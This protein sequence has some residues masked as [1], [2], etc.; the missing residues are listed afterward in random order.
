MNLRTRLGMLS[1]A[2]AAVSAL[3]VSGAL[4]VADARAVV[5]RADTHLV[6]AAAQA[7][8]L[9]R[10]IKN[11]PDADAQPEV[12]DEP[13]TI[14]DVTL[15]LISTPGAVGDATIAGPLT[16]ADVDVARRQQPS[17]PS[18]RTVD[19]ERYRVYLSPFGSS[20]GLVV[21]VWPRATG[22]AAQ[23]EL[24]LRLFAFVLVTA[25][26]AGLLGRLIAG[27]ALAPVA[28]LTRTAE[29]I[30]STGD[31]ARRIE[32]TEPDEV[33]RLTTTINSMLASLEQSVSAQ[34]QLVADA[35]HELRTP[36][37][38]LRINLDLLAEAPALSDPNAPHL[39]AHARRQ[40]DQLTELVADLVALARYGQSAAPRHPVRLDD[41][42]LAV[43]ARHADRPDTRPIELDV[44]AAVVDGDEEALHRA[45]SNLVD[46]AIAW[47]PPDAV[48]T[49]RVRDGRVDVIDRGPGID[50]GDVPHVFERF[51]RSPAARSKPGSGLG[52]A[53]VHQ[54]A[55]QHGGSV[56]VASSPAGSTLT[57]RIPPVRPAPDGDETP[58]A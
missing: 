9:A 44:Q 46:N 34:R 19:G 28:R 13:L 7:D 56:E 57:M 15:Q 48:V 14:G 35:S 36:L 26:I 6:A 32:V 42:A 2:A 10:S 25:L 47:S 51:Y 23:R 39:V 3:V 50:A 24:A 30:T 5:P 16:G 8:Q 21:A 43:A 53:I 33:G 22:S 31:L 17:A 55:T 40:V 1:G 41:I 52:L 38:S 27:R 11:R 4:L 58:G 18:W 12:L 54:V 49:V 29:R 45:V 37:T 20:S